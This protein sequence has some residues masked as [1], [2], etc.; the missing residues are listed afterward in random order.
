MKI[1][2][3]LSALILFSAVSITKA[4]Q[5]LKIGHVNI[6]ELVQ[7]HP[8]M[9]SLSAILE[10][11]TK[12][13]QEIYQEMIEEHEAAIEKFEAESETY[14]DF[15]KQTRQNEILEQSQKIQNYNQT[16]QQQLQRRNMELIQPI[17]A[18]INQQISNIAGAQGL[19]YVLDVSTGAVAYVS[20]ESEDLTPLVLE[21]IKGE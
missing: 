15:V 16:A 2:L 12:D 18:E 1:K 13:M 4:Q 21:A 19:S 6:Q 17:Y 10:Q 14:S 5:T 8:S 11:E 9:D 3:L 20:P 7:K